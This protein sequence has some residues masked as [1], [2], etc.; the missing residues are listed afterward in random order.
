MCD[1]EA[2]CLLHYLR[3]EFS[4]PLSLPKW[5]ICFFGVII[6]K[7]AGEE[8]LKGQ[9]LIFQVCVFC[10]LSGDLDL[11]NFVECVKTGI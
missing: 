4:Y 3:W 8:G 1:K 10:I 11:A 6:F 2:F 9:Q 5:V 7:D